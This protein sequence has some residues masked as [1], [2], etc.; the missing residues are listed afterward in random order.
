M[1]NNYSKNIGSV[2]SGTMREED[3]IPA[4]LDELE[5]MKPLR[6]EHSKEIKEIRKR[7]ELPNY[8]ES[9][10]AGYDLNEFL[11]E[12]LDEYAPPYFYFGAHPGDGADYGYWLSEEWEENLKDNG[13]LKVNDLSEVP[14]T[15]SGEVAVVSD[16]GNVTLYRFHRGRKFEI[17]SLV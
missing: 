1:K 8:F 6:R 3:L 13:G 11:F 10:E 4:F 9:E 2:S 17:W 7:M 16:H 15:F 5:S 14:K 12:A